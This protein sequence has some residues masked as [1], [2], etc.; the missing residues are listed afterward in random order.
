MTLKTE[1]A[2]CIPVKVFFD[3][4]IYLPRIYLFIKPLSII[5]KFALQISCREKYILRKSFDVVYLLKWASYKNISH[6]VSTRWKSVLL[7][8]IIYYFFTYRAHVN[9]PLNMVNE[10]N[11]TW[12]GAFSLFLI[13]K[14]YCRCSSASL[15]LVASSRRIS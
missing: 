2:A 1:H 12:N 9:N 6:A 10:Q 11:Y 5:P 14:R 3:S 13:S 7:V 4:N 15:R 8:D